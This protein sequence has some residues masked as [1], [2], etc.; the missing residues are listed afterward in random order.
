MSTVINM[1]LPNKITINGDI[2]L[3]AKVIS[4]RFGDGY[5]QSAPDGLNH[6]IESFNVEWGPLSEAET[7]T[8]WDALKSVIASGY[9]L[10]TL[11]D[12]RGS[13][14]KQFKIKDRRIKKTLIGNCRTKISCTLYESFDII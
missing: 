14:T 8:V 7:T 1:P 9:I 3:E 13:G 5:E 12:T 10:W 2:E 4:V 6:I 11:T